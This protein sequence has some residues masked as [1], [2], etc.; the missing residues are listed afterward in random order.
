[1]VKEGFGLNPGRSARAQWRKLSAPIERLIVLGLLDPSQSIFDYGCGQ[2]LDMHYLRDRGFEVSGWDPNWLPD[3]EIKAADV[4]LM[5]FVIDCIADPAER[6]EALQ[7]AWSLAGDY[8]MVTVRRDRS[9]RRLTRY[10]DGWLTQSRTFQRLF[11]QAEF[12]Q[13]LKRSFCA[14]SL[15]H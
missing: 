1:M 15:Q 7:R 13:F 11:T 2:G 9:L 14:R 4:V 6:V 10:S 12:Y 8:M 5:N 3:G